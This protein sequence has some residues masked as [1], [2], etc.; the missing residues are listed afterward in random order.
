MS[1][2]PSTHP[3]RPTLA[4]RLYPA[5]GAPLGHIATPLRYETYV[6]K[7][8]VPSRPGSMD[9]F[10]LPSVEFGQRKDV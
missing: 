4:P 6:P 9:A 5:V 7:A 2:K 1:R 3:A 8:T 10:Q